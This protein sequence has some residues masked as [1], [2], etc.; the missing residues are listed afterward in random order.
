MDP[1]PYTSLRD[2]D[3]LALCIW[4]EARGEGLLGKRGVGHVVLNRVNARSFFGQDV[5]SV[6]LKPFAFSSFNPSDPNADQWPTGIDPSWTDSTNAAEA[7]LS[8]QDTD[9]TSGA[10]YYFSPPLTAPPHAWGPV[11]VTLVVG[12]LTFCKPVPTNASDVAE[13]GDPG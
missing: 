7:V 4:R 2:Q 9:L 11:G 5:Q 12:N 3:L 8:G 13:A 6:I 1:Q 10:L